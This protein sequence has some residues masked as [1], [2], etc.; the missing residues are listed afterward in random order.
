MENNSATWKR[1]AREL[2]DVFTQSMIE[3]GYEA[4]ERS[5]YIYR[6]IDLHELSTLGVQKADI[7]ET[8][9]FA[10]KNWDALQS[11]TNLK[12]LPEE[13]T[14]KEITSKWRYQEFA[15]AT[16]C[17]IEKY[18]KRFTK[19]EKKESTKGDSEVLNNLKKREVILK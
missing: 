19:E 5:I 6:P 11:S 4:K 17:G 16:Q 2:F 14:F 8:I 10:V 7:A 18:L 9:S 12:N 15:Y 13:P 1:K 3:C